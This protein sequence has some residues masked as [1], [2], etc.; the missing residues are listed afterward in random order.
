MKTSKVRIPVYT[1]DQEAA[2]TAS[3]AI[4]VVLTLV[5]GPALIFKAWNYGGFWDVVG[6]FMFMIGSLAC[7]LTSSIYHALPVGD[8]K[9]RFRV[10]D[11]NAIYLFIIGTYGPYCLSGLMRYSNAWAFSIYGIVISLGIIGI[12]LNSINLEKFKVITMILDILEGW[13]IIVAFYPLIQ[14]VSFYPC[15]FLLLMGGVAYTVGAILYG[16]GAKKNQWFHFV[17]HIFCLL[18]TILMF[19]SVYGYLIG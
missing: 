2:N 8:F 18:G 16:I 17:F 14:A 7:Y 4:G 11:H 1:F 6:A 12:I 15:V 13:A 9:R 3:H 10:F 19:I 5:F